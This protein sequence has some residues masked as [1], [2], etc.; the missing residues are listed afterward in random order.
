MHIR[1]ILG[2]GGLCAG[3][4]L[5]GITA[6]VRGAHLIDIALGTDRWRRPST[7]GKAIHA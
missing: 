7:I 5:A 6:G 4:L 3:A 2:V 1:T